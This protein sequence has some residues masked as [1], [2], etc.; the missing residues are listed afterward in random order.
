MSKYDVRSTELEM[1]DYP[2]ED[3][4]VLFSNLR[5]LELINKLTGGPHLTFKFL[6]RILKGSSGTVTIV[7]IG[8]GA[9]DMMQYIFDNAH[10]LPVKIKL[11]GVDLMQE[12]EEYFNK[13]HAAIS[14][15]VTIHICDYQ[16]YFDDGGECDIAIAGLFT[17]HLT[18]DQLVTFFSLV[19]KY[20]KIGAVVN[21]LH[22]H[23][24]AY[25]G[26]KIPTQLLSKSKF[27]KNDAPLSVLRGFRKQELVDALVKAGVKK[28]DVSWQWAFRYLITI[29][30]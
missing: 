30:K 8:F 6:E 20:A 5:E 27:T 26:I 17:H 13:Y 15:K 4:E 12:A 25:Y 14:D 1:M 23:P 18:D 22:R 3:K 21:D 29:L 24:I 2:I 28:Y 10:K 19:N 9:G 11:V 16:Q 7:D